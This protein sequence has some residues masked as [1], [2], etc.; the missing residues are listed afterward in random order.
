MEVTF[1]GVR[2]IDA[3]VWTG[4]LSAADAKRLPGAPLKIAGPH[5]VLLQRPG[6]DGAALKAP[7]ESVSVLALGHGEAAIYLSA[8]AAEPPPTP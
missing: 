3:G 7:F 4:Q 5:V 2:A 6:W 1:G 8:E